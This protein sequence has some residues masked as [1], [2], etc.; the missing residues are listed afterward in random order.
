MIIQLSGSPMS[1]YEKTRQFLK[2][3]SVGPCEDIR[4][5]LKFLFLQSVIQESEMS[6]GLWDRTF[7]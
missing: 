7:E 2:F 4:K 3:L 1:S 5:I 6:N